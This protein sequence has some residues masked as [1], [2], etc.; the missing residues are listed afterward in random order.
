MTI[1]DILLS[2]IVICDKVSLAPSQELWSLIP[3]TINRGHDPFYL[4]ASQ[5]KIYRTILSNFPDIN[6]FQSTGFD[7]RK[8]MTLR[9][10]K[11]IK[12]WKYLLTC[13]PSNKLKATISLTG[14]AVQENLIFY[15]SQLFCIYLYKITK[16]ELAISLSFCLLNCPHEWSDMVRLC[17]HQ[18]LGVFILFLYFSRCQAGQG[19]VLS[20]NQNRILFFFYDKYLRSHVNH[21]KEAAAIFVQSSRMTMAISQAI[22]RGCVTLDMH[23]LNTYR[24]ASSGNVAYSTTLV[25]WVRAE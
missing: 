9:L 5:N 3:F 4:Y 13:W 7:P 23:F 14:L 1:F 2:W 20:R 22:E 8:E 25:C 21:R 6:T 17:F 10:Q 19:C 16:L 11:M 18:D 12:G 24:T 15:W